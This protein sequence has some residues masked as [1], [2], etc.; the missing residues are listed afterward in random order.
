MGAGGVGVRVSVSVVV[1]YRPDGCAHRQEAWDYVRRWWADRHPGWEVIAATDGGGAWCKAAAVARAA[2]A[3]AGDVLVVA[4]A[5]V[6]CDGVAWAV[7]QVDRGAP[8]AV[9]HRS[10]YRLSAAGARQV[11]A[12]GA[13]PDPLSTAA[14]AGGAVAELHAGVVGG[15]LVVLP[16][17]VWA[18][19]PMDVRFRGW[20]QEDA[21]WARALTVVEG[22]PA[23]GNARL[24]HLWHPPQARRSRSVGSDAGRELW[25][26]YRRTV[27]RASM[28][29]LV[30][31]GRPD[32]PAGPAGASVSGQPDSAASA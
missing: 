10:V 12:T 21:A 6:V 15:G 28:V 26:R 14:R 27:D 8:W 4:D 32:A 3:A 13:L 23:R 16:A 24:W 17:G 20:G 29:A 1:P 22:A 31:Q 2:A 7:D 30:E 18:R 19:T 9:P 25:L 5:D 11:Y